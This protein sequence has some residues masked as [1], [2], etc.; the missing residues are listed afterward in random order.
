MQLSP[1]YLEKIAAAEQVGE[2]RMVLRFLEQRFDTLSTDLLTRIESLR[3]TNQAAQPSLIKGLCLL[4][5]LH[6]YNLQTI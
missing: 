5:S 6:G 1:L 2:Q 4:L 3:W